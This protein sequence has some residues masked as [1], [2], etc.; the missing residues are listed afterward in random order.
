MTAKEIIDFLGNVDGD[1]IVTMLQ[2][3]EDNPMT[4]GV[5]IR[6]IVRIRSAKGDRVIALIPE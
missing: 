6:D 5:D 4:D 1:Y 2:C 3:A